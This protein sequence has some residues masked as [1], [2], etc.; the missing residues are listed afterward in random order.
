MIF[1]NKI[2]IITKTKFINFYAL[3]IIK[4]EKNIKKLKLN[5]LHKV[6]AL[7]VSLNS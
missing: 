3:K 5:L 2:D 6:Y 7:K 4:Q 1:L